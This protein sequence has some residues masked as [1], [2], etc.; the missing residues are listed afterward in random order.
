MRRCRLRDPVPVL[1]DD[2]VR[3]ERANALGDRPCRL[4]RCSGCTARLSSLQDLPAR[5]GS[6]RPST[7]CAIDAAIR[8][9]AGVFVVDL[10]EVN[11]LDS[12]GI[13]VLL[14]ARALLGRDER[15]LVIICPAGPTRRIF[16]VAGV[17]DLLVLFE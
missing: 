7:D 6:H 3:A 9:S 12:T 10:C 13:N 2:D 17:A 11:F 16:E 4:P 14:R 15:A 5:R 1:A 8:E